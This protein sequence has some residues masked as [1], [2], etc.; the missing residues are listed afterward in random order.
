M[1]S[2]R[3]GLLGLERL[4]RDGGE[5]GRWHSKNSEDGSTGA[6]ELG[7]LCEVPR[8]GLVWVELR[9]GKSVGVGMGGA[10]RRKKC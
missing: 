5:H 1:D 3:F 8:E 7:V 4:F 2:K 6:Y 9:G 10:K